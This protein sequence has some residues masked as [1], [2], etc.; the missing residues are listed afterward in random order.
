MRWEDA[1]TRAWDDWHEGM[2]PD[3][4]PQMNPSFR[5]GFLAGVGWS[6]SQYQPATEEPEEEM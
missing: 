2:D 6:E 5:R 3:D 1:A 4:I